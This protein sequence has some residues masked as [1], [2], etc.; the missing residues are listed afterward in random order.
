MDAFLE[1]RCRKYYAP[2]MGQPTLA[3]GVY[4]RLLRSELDE[5]PPDHTT[6]SRTRRLLEVKTHREVFRWVLGVI[7]EKGLLQGKTLGIDATTLEANAA[8]RSIV[9]WDSGE[10]YQEFLRK[11]A[12]KSGITTPTREELMRGDRKRRLCKDL[13]GSIYDRDKTV[14]KPPNLSRL[15]LALSEKQSP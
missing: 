7:A 8:L 14:T 15:G 4:F 10:S 9:R 3:P 6:I 13:R 1:E 11:L 2:K 5:A 12:Q